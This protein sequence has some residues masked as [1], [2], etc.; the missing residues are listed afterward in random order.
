MTQ[1]LTMTTTHKFPLQAVDEA[2]HFSDTTASAPGSDDEGSMAG[3]EHEEGGEGV[4]AGG[5]AGGSD[6][7]GS[8]TDMASVDNLSANN[9]RYESGGGGR[10]QKNADHPN[11][12][13]EDN[14][15][16]TRLSGLRQV[17]IE[18]LV[19]SLKS[20]EEVGG[21]RCIPYMQLALALTTDLDQGWK[22]MSCSRCQ[23]LCQFLLGS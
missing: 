8:M 22:F 4:E 18:K 7:G 3:D 11:E 20:L 16:E 14:D 15:R 1:L 10:E 21:T 2:A 6:S 5:V 19:S 9:Y 17:L 12:D 13:S 23:E